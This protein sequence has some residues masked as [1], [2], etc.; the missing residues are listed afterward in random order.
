MY[1]GK[2][3]CYVNTIATLVRYYSI[4]FPILQNLHCGLEQNWI[5]GNL[6]VTIRFN[7]SQRQVTSQA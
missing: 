3:T 7:Y 5:E 1:Q 6:K 2:G 4:E